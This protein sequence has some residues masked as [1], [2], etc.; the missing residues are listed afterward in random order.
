MGGG[1]NW[2]KGGNERKFDIMSHGWWW[3][4]GPLLKGE[5]GGRPRA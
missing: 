4:E 1:A 5:G 2:G 3:G